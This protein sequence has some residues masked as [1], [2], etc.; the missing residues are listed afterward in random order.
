M[1]YYV[2]SGTLNP[3]HSLTRK[4]V[5]KSDLQQTAVCDDS[6]T[7]PAHVAAARLHYMYIV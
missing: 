1:T 2:S 3:T 7:G 6:E 5:L 4:K